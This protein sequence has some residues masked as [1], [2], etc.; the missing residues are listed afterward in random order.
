MFIKIYG[1]DIRPLYELA[2]GFE[3]S[4]SS[5]EN[6]AKSYLNSESHP[7]LYNKMYPKGGAREFESFR[8]N[9]YIDKISQFF[10]KEYLN[11]RWGSNE[12]RKFKALISKLKVYLKVEKEFHNDDIN[13]LLDFFK[14]ISL[15]ENK[16]NIQMVLFKDLWGL[17]YKSNPSD[18]YIKLIDSYFGGRAKR[19][20]F[21]KARQELTNYQRMDYSDSEFRE[22]L[23]PKNFNS[24]CRILRSK[25]E[26][27]KWSFDTFYIAK[28]NINFNEMKDIS[29]LISIIKLADFSKN[30]AENLERLFP[31]EGNFSF[32]TF[33]RFLEKLGYRKTF[34]IELSN[35]GC[36]EKLLEK[37]YYTFKNM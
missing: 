6:F 35:N 24:I 5:F 19:K 34:S 1:E 25:Y 28:F 14:S 15:L 8:I 21:F 3:V 26:I 18:T 11:K 13:I 37:F 16:S 12:K 20:R 22:K 23:I 2:E 33:Y 7:T 27:E 31:G 4:F 29:E 9:N 36:S 17:F 30:S 32:K 10:R